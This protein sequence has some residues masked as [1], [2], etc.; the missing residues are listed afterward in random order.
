MCHRLLMFQLRPVIISRTQFY[1]CPLKRFRYSFL[2]S[3]LSTLEFCF[4]NKAWRLDLCHA[5]FVSY[6]HTVGTANLATAA[7]PAVIQ[8]PRQGSCENEAER[9]AEACGLP[10]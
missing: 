2:V 7:F 1:H 6:R 5:V 10:L 9:D 3:N 8:K 4:V